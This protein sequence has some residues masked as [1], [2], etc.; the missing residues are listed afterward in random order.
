MNNFKTQMNINISIF[1]V[2]FLSILSLT[3]LYAQDKLTGI[4]ELKDGEFAGAQVKVY[5]D[6][7]NLE[8]KLFTVPQNMKQS[9][10]NENDV[11]WMNIFKES[12]GKYSIIDIVKVKGDCSDIYSSKNINFSDEN[13]VSVTAGAINT[14]PTGSLQK[15]TKVNSE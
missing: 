12:E 7:S 2:I 6:G 10:Y 11:K 3:N 8:S 4:W 14:D 5:K 13:S 9:C 1:A 15:W